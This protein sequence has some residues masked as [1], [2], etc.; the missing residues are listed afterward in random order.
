MSNFV[1]VAFQVQLARLFGA[2]SKEA[3]AQSRTPALWKK[4]LQKVLDELYEYAQANIETDELH[5]L[6]ICT[7][8]A[9]AHES[10]KEDSFWPGYVEGMVRL[11]LLLLGDYPDHRKRKTGKKKAEHYHLSRLRKLHFLQNQDQKVKTMLA[12]Q[13]VG[14]PKLSE[15]PRIA[16]SK[17]RAEY[18]YEASYRDFIRWYK[19]MYPRDYAAL[20]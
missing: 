15:P 19:C 9:S 17:F 7:A 4:T 14:F 11:N 13:T 18:G 3:V 1:P 16:L 8:F 10:L 2:T 6:M 12:A 20:F 5:W